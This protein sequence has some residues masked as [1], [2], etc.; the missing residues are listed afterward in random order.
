MDSASYVLFIYDTILYAGVYDILEGT[1]IKFKP[2]NIIHFI[3]CVLHFS[4]F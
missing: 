3:I 2:L 4:L 1:I